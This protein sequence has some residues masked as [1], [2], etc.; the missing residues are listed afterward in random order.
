VASTL[1]AA[2]PLLQQTEAAPPETVSAEIREAVGTDALQIAADGKSAADFWLRP[3]VPLAET[4][5]SELGVAFGQL[6]QC[7]LLGV[8]RLGEAW[9][10]YKK[11]PIPPGVYTLRYAIHP[12]DGNHMGVSIYRDYLLLVPVSD[13]TSVDVDWSPELL[14]EKS[15][16][17]TGTTH[18]AV[19]ALFPVWEEPSEP[20][21]VRNE[22]D[23]WTLAVPVGSV[24]PTVGLVVE[25]HGEG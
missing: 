8:V 13:D 25:G 9:A 5:S 11:N 6:R 18:P 16:T 15:K 20:V 17:T 4:P 2:D 12:A 23:Q 7:T 19:L 1:Q 14:W 22:M 24:S 3:E 10:D 21:M